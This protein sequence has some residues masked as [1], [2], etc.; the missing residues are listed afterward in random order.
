[1]DKYTKLFTLIIFCCVTGILVSFYHQ[2]KISDL[3]EQN[4][5]LKQ[6]I[7]EIL[8]TPEIEAK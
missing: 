2:Q 5:E 6:R 7:Q 3:T 1:M 8:I 4:K